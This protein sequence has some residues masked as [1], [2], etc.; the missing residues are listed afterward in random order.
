MKNYDFVKKAIRKWTKRKR[1]TQLS[2]KAILKRIHTERRRLEANIARLD[3]AAMTE[4]AVVPLVST[5]MLTRTPPGSTNI[6]AW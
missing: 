5:C 1:G 3:E 2:K 4:P 6:R